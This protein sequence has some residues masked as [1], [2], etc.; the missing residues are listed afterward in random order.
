MKK[1]EIIIILIFF[2][3]LYGYMVYKFG[4]KEGVIQDSKNKLE[5]IKSELEKQGIIVDLKKTK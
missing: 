3:S 2:L 1:F 5:Y 4:Y